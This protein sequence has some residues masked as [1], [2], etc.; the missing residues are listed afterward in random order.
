MGCKGI[1]VNVT[2]N[3]PGREAEEVL[4]W[5]DSLELQQSDQMEW[6]RPLFPEKTDEEIL[7][8]DLD[9]NLVLH[10]YTL[11]PNTTA[12]HAMPDQV[13]KDFHRWY[14]KVLRTWCNNPINKTKSLNRAVF[15]KLWTE[16]HDLWVSKATIWA[17]ARKVGFDN[18][19]LKPHL[20]DQTKFVL[21]QAI[22]GRNDF[23][24]GTPRNILDRKFGDL[25]TPDHKELIEGTQTAWK[26]TKSDLE[27]ENQRLREAL[28]YIASQKT[29]LK[30]LGFYEN[31]NNNQEVDN[32]ER[33]NIKS[34]WGDT[35]NCGIQ[36]KRAENKEKERL[37]KEKSHA[38][39]AKVLANKE[40]AAAKLEL[41]AM[42]SEDV[43]VCMP[44]GATAPKLEQ[45]PGYKKL[46]KRAACLKLLHQ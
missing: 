14:H 23:N 43:N 20:V 30:A 24:D 36:E 8:M 42:A 45:G 40:A 5:L 28:T 9:F 32:E 34:Y 18:D 22:R 3:G 33:T 35:L 37:A 16:I 2:D 29:T 27:M 6:I 31:A 15:C 39:H 38:Y 4:E 46:S 25:L 41:Q 7:A 13:F 10:Q 11:P 17:A 19:Q 26:K 44:I 12:I 21:A 1:I